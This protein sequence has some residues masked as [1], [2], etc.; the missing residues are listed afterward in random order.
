ML[1]FFKVLGFDFLI[2]FNDLINFSI[3]F[4]SVKL[5]FFLNFL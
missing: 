4:F 5:G 3:I 2:F 1:D